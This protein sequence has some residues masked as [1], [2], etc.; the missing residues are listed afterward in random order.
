MAGDASRAPTLDVILPVIR[1]D[2]RR[3]NAR[4]VRAIVEM[5]KANGEPYLTVVR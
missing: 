5:L 1:E 4:I 2:I 3:E